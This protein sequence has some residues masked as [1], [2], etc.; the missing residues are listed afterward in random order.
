MDNYNFVAFKCRQPIG[1]FFTS[2]IPA[3]V[4]RECAES[5]PREIND[6]DSE[7]RSGIQRVINKARLV[8]IRK[9]LRTADAAFPSSII[10]S[11]NTSVGDVT[12]PDLQVFHNDPLYLISIPKKKGIFSI[13]DG[14]HRLYSFD[15]ETSKDFD[16]PVTIFFDLPEEEKAYLFST[17]NSTQMKVNKSLVYDLFDLAETRSPQKTAHSVAQLMNS[18][19]LSPLFRRIKLL[20]VNPKYNEELLYK[21][22]IT[23]GTFVERVMRLITSDPA[24][25]RDVAKRGGQ[26]VLSGE[27]MKQGLIFR[28]F[29]V[30]NQD[31]AILKVL[32]SFFDSVKTVF[33]DEWKDD[34]N[35]LSRSIGFGALINLL[36]LL[37]KKGAAEKDVS[38][39]FFMKEMKAIHINYKA[40]KVGLTF[41]NFPAAGNGET[42]LARQLALWAG[43]GENSSKES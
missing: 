33:A 5:A 2:V 38:A 42:K 13:I 17:I 34:K 37:F 32:T 24:G 39:A 11:L 16:L 27:E 36:V 43:F 23:Q 4:L 3:S 14:Q 21:G 22:S 31:A 15:E 6:P 20:G 29:F 35:P 9:Y 1:E 26:L 40:S 25:D 8:E 28:N 30:S 7:Q 12:G 18:D 41:Q 19:K 10:L